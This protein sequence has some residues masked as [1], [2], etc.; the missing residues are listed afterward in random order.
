MRIGPTPTLKE[1]SQKRPKL[2]PR[3]NMLKRKVL[4]DDTTVLHAEYVFFTF[5]SVFPYPNFP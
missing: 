5:L 4:L 1:T 2:T 3:L